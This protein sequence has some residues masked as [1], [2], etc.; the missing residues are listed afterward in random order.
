MTTRR[1]IVMDALDRWRDE[2][3][4]TVEEHAR[5][6]ARASAEPAAWDDTLPHEHATRADTGGATAHVSAEDRGSFAVNSM[7]FVGGLLLGAALVALTFFLNLEGTAAAWTLLGLGAAAVGGGMA[8]HYLAPG[9]NGLEEAMFGAGLV[10]VAVAPFQ[11]GETIMIG[12]LGM[13]LAIA[14]LVVRR[15]DGPTVVVAG[16]AYVSAS[17]AALGP[18]FFGSD[19]T[20]SYMLWWLA[21]VAYGLLMLVWRTRSW[22][23]AALGLYVLPLVLSFGPVLDQWGRQLGIESSTFVQLVI[24]AYLGIWFAVGIALGIR[25]LVA[26]A[27]AGLTIDA[28]VFAADLGGPGTAVVVLVLLG[29]LLVWQAEFLRAYFG[30]RGRRP[31]P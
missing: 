29:G 13:A 22:T 1:G 6:I 19:V 25:G 5:L 9:R 21:V 8:M 12:L 11:N 24:G 14:S 20:Q 7:Q 30:R 31:A 28:V 2:G 10:A 15:G 16:A 27:A 3:V 4:L 23:S 26:G 17:F 18:D